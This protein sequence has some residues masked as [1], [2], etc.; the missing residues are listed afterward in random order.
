MKKQELKGNNKIETKEKQK[1]IGKN[2]KRNTKYIVFFILFVI[3]AYFIYVI[4][5]LVRE[6]TDIFTIEE[7]K[8]YLEE[9]NTGYVIRDE[10]VIKGNQY[11]N[12]IDQIKNEGEKV[13][14]DE[15][16]FRYYSKNEDGLVKQIAELDTKIQEALKN[17]SDLYSSDITLIEKQIDEE[18]KNLNKLTDISKLTEADKQKHIPKT[19]SVILKL[20]INELGMIENNVTFCYGDFEFNPFQPNSLSIPR[21]MA[22]ER[23]TIAKMVEDGFVVSPKH[24]N[25]VLIDDE[26]TYEFLD[27]KIEEYMAKFEVLISEE[28]KKKQ[29][30]QPRIGTIGV[31]IQNDLLSIDLS[32]INYNPEELEH[33]I[34]N[35]QLKK[36]YY[37]LKDGRFLKL[38]QNENMDFLDKLVDGMDID[39]KKMKNGQVMLPINRSL[40][41][42]QLLEKNEDIQVNENQEYKKLIEDT[43]NVRNDEEIQIPKQ[44]DNILRDYQKTGYK[45][46]K[47]LERY[48]MGGILADDMGLRKN[49]PSNRLIPKTRKRANFYCSMSKL[50]IFELEK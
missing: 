12:G 29:V 50:F 9:A 22:Q 48:K 44:L 24:Y 42:N 46:L 32:S 41:L 47:V 3:M 31:K 5:L 49:P 33:I 20:D 11:K 43:T 39:F 2:K 25:M 14:K 19:L 27:E 15:T 7:G 40:Y 23:A 10:V 1:D 34:E 16:V 17:Q 26:K 6:P 30:I 38:E 35:Y 4:Y 36:K 28:F 21:N 8:L 18:I 13:A 37:K 45:W